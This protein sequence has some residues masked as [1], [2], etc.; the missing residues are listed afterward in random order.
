MPTRKRTEENLFSVLTET[1]FNKLYKENI[2]K[3]L[4]EKSKTEQAHRRTEY[5]DFREK[6]W[7]LKNGKCYG[8]FTVNKRF[9]ILGRQDLC[10]HLL[11]FHQVIGLQQAGVI[12]KVFDT[13]QEKY[14]KFNMS[15]EEAAQAN[16]NKEDIDKKIEQEVKQAPTPTE[17]EQHAIDNHNAGVTEEVG[18]NEKEEETKTLIGEASVKDTTGGKKTR[19]R[20]N[21]TRKRKTH[22]KKGKKLRRKRR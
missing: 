3:E 1:G 7:L 9:H 5:K 12:K 20:N 6:V 4:A 13:A 11:M 19:K 16:K 14:N 22:K 8:E 17:Q 2:I 21:K 18:Y 10:F 15:P